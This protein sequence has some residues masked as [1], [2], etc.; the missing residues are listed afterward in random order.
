MD[1]DTIHETVTCAAPEENPPS[2]EIFD[3][4]KSFQEALGPGVPY[5]T[6]PNDKQ[7]LHQTVAMNIDRPRI[8][9]LPKTSAIWIAF[10]SP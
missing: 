10:P 1:H 8:L 4:S 7:A 2:V 9:V 5:L 3:S 6:I